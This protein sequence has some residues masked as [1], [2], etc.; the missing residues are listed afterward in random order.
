[1]RSSRRLWVRLVLA[2]RARGLGAAP[3]TLLALAPLHALLAW[4]LVGVAGALAAVAGLLLVAG[5]FLVSVVAVTVTDRH[6][7]AFVLPAAV[8]SYVVKVAAL[9]SLLTLPTTPVTR[10]LAYSVIVGT[11]AWELAHLVGV[12]R[13]TQSHGTA[14]SGFTDPG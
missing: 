8:G 13:A 10:C 9:V 7:P 11:L 1:M 4:M 2:L 3:V 12:L 6:A 14:V 5:F